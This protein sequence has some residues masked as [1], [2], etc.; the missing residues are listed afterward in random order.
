ML[1]SPRVSSRERAQLLANSWT[2]WAL[3]PLWRRPIPPMPMP[4][5]A[6]VQTLDLPNW[7]GLMNGLIDELIDMIRWG[8]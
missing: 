6:N 3:W 1:S 8:N 7:M 2:E 5:S 4:S